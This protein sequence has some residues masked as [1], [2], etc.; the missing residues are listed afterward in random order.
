MIYGNLLGLEAVVHTT[1]P[2][3]LRFGL[4]AEEPCG[5]GRGSR[6]FLLFRQRCRLRLTSAEIEPDQT[7]SGQIIRS[8]T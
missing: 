8:S 7:R 6:R 3:S 2:T 4:A 1:L 5:L